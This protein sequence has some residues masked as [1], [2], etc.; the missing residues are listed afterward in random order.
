MKRRWELGKRHKKRVQEKGPTTY[1]G[2]AE[3]PLNAHS[4]PT[5]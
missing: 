2:I 4:M 5:R 3:M 1:E